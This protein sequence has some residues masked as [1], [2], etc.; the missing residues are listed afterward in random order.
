MSFMDWFAGFCLF[1]W[2]CDGVSDLFKKPKPSRD[3]SSTVTSRLPTGRSVNPPSP[4]M[5]QKA[6]NLD[7]DESEIDDLQERIDYLEEQLDSCDVLSDRYDRIQDKIDSLQD[8]L[9]RLEDIRDRYEELR[10]D[11]DDY[12]DSDDDDDC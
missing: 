2:L 5:R 3:V 4:V 12:N 6:L 9:D 10:D 8:R 11:I 1:D 7:F